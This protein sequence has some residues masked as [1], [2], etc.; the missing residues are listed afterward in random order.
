MRTSRPDADIVQTQRRFAVGD[1]HLGYPKGLYA[2]GKWP[3][4]G[5]TGARKSCVVATFGPLMAVRTLQH[6]AA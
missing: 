4:E 5:C 2:A 3:L 6:I 1:V